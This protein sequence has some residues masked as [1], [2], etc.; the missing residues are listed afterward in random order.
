MKKAFAAVW[1]GDV[2]VVS[3]SVGGTKDQPFN[4]ETPRGAKHRAFEALKASGADLGVGLEGGIDA[5]P[6][7]YFVTG[8]CAIADTAGKITYGRSFGVPIPAYVVDRMKKEGKELGDIVDELLDKKNTKQAEGFFGFATKNMVTR[9]K[10]YIDM[11]VAAL[12]PR[13]FPE[14]YK[15]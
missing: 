12:A 3:C 9:E 6:E 2:E 5:R 4:D 1:E 13:V 10:G 7:G 11:V 14:F 8:W 15:E